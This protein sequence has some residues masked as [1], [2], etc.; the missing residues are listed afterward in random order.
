MTKK[1]GLKFNFKLQKESQPQETAITE[2]LTF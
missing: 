1:G 2:D